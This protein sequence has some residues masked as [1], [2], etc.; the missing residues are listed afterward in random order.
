MKSLRSLTTREELQDRLDHILRHRFE[1]S[2]KINGPRP[3]LGA[4]KAE[5]GIGIAWLVNRRLLKLQRQA[6]AA[7]CG[8]SFTRNGDIS[9][10]V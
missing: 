5:P 6:D 3:R 1:L 9:Y 10:R 8:V 7:T 2:G 4:R